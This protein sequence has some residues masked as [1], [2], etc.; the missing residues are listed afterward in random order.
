ML[1]VCFEGLHTPLNFLRKSQLSA[2]G[3][4]VYVYMRKKFRKSAKI[5][6]I[7]DTYTSFCTFPH[8]HAI[9]FSKR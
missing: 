5:V 2:I 1:G 8:K 4:C 9:Y 6:K 7:A 3:V